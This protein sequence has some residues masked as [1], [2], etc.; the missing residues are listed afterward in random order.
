MPR[1]SYCP[2]CDSEYPPLKRSRV[3]PGGWVM[4]A[5]FLVLGVASVV[6]GAFTC[7]CFVGSV[8]LP[9]SML[10]LLLREEYRVCVDCGER[11]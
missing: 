1:K 10:G 2:Y 7:V 8:F 9:L 11:L 6:A 5:M 4:M 3:Q